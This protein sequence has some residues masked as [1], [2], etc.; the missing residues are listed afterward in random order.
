M[1]CS[2]PRLRRANRPAPPLLLEGGDLATT[3]GRPAHRPPGADGPRTHVTVDIGA[4]LVDGVL[5]WFLAH[6]VVRRSWLR[7]R[8]IVV[9]NAAHLGA[10]NI[11]PRAHPGDGRLDLLDGDLPLGQRLEARNRL[12]GGTHVPHPGIT[13]RRIDAIQLELSSPTPVWIDGIDIG[14]ARTLSVRVEP[15]AVDVWV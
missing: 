15:D 4:A 11:A 3:L 10:W 6:L 14:R 8:V 5:H 2:W 7:G 12:R 9:A 13:T 1:P